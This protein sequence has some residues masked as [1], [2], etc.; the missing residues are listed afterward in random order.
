MDI[1]VFYFKPHNPVLFTNEYFLEKSTSKYKFICKRPLKTMMHR[2]P[3]YAK[4]ARRRPKS[5][6]VAI[7]AE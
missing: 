5:N 3:E 2:P 6:I 7:L 4:K 1:N